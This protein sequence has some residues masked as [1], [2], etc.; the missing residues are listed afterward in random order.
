MNPSAGSFHLPQPFSQFSAGDIYATV[1]PGFDRTT[2]R[3][4]YILNEQKQ[5]SLVRLNQARFWKSGGENYLVVMVDI[6]GYDEQFGIPGSCGVCASTSPIAVLKVQ[7]GKLKLVAKQDDEFYSSKNGEDNSTGFESFWY[8]G[9]DYDISFDLAPYRLNSKEL[10]IG[11]RYQHMWI[12]AY[13]FST[14]LLL[15][16][17]EGKRIRKVFE[18]LAIERGWYNGPAP[19]LKMEKTT[20]TYITRP[21][22]EQFNKIIVNRKTRKCIADWDTYDCDG[23]KLIGTKQ[24]TWTFDGTRFGK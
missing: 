20:S 11:L 24:E 21:T 6:G 22:N 1:F 5:P 15:Y 4:P 13:S 18:D 3:V 9:H 12:P 16:R 10:L 14:T 23:G 19:Q 7:D 8:T 2:G 17:I